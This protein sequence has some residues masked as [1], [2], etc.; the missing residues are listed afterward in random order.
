[1]GGYFKDGIGFPLADA[2]FNQIKYT[3]NSVTRCFDFLVFKFVSLIVLDKTMI[4][5]FENPF[6]F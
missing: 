2:R 5:C 1:M 6:I 3:I 4:E